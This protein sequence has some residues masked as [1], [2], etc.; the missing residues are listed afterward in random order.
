MNIKMLGMLMISITV[1]S[2]CQSSISPPE[3]KVYA[4]SSSPSSAYPTPQPTE[5]AMPTPISTVTIVARPTAVPRP[6]HPPNPPTPNIPPG[7][8]WLTVTAPKTPL[9]QP[10]AIQFP[11]LEPI[12]TGFPTLVESSDLFWYLD[13]PNSQSNIVLRSVQ[14][15]SYA[16]GSG[17]K[18][19]PGYSINLNLK[20]NN[21]VYLQDLVP[22]IDGEWAL[23]LYGLGSP[24]LINL[25]NGESRVITQLA[26][27]ASATWTLN[28]QYFI[29]LPFDIP[30]FV[31][32]I[33]PRSA[34]INSG[35]IYPDNNNPLDRGALAGLAPFDVSQIYLDA[36]NLGN[37][38]IATDAP[39]IQF[40]IQNS[41]GNSRYVLGEMQKAYMLEGS[42][43]KISDTKAVFVANTFSPNSNSRSTA[44]QITQLYVIDII[45]GQY[46]AISELARGM[47]YIHKPLILDNST[48]VIAAYDNSENN[49]IVHL[50]RLDIST[51]YQM[52][53]ARFAADSVSSFKIS[54]DKKW[55]SLTKNYENYGEVILLS[56]DDF[57]LHVI[58]GPTPRNAPVFW[59]K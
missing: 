32:I 47:A 46:Q 19:T 6:T 5:P 7:D 43:R 33:D 55:I 15:A 9:P 34:H 3:M 54:P 36:I 58:A 24:F 37:A 38:P 41:Q 27:L 51:G 49:L 21:L 18:T 14:I 8:L 28:N 29:G 39:R 16:Q 45:T 23:G 31:P 56:L 17:V 48:A 20:A 35:L 52:E 25:K 1:I 11:T 59:A 26:Q 10:T 2:G 57:S 40:G 30:G 13:Y 12:S 4:S 50:K 44:N 42:L 53:I 22:S